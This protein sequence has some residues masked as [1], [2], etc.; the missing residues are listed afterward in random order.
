VKSDVAAASTASSL[1][2]DVVRTLLELLEE[3][4]AICDLNLVVVAHN[5]AFSHFCG[6]TSAEG[7]SVRELLDMDAFAMP[8]DGTVSVLK[9]RSSSRDNRATAVSVSRRG[10]A[11]VVTTRDLDSPHDSLAAA[12][13][14]LDA[15]AELEAQLLEIG[16]SV[17]GAS[18]EEELVAAV[19]RGVK[20]L[21]PG[22]MYC[23]RIIDPQTG[24]LTSLFAQGQLRLI[25]R[26]VL[27]LKQ[28]MV[29]KTH[30]DVATLPHDHIVFT[31]GEIPALFQDSV[32]AISAPLVASGRL[33][34]AINVE[35]AAEVTFDGPNNVRVLSQL[36]NQVAVA[37]RNAKLIDELTFVRK[38]LEEL[39]E[40]ANALI[41]VVDSDRR[42]AVFNDALAH[43]TG[44]SKQSVLGSSV[45][46]LLPESERFK[47]MKTIDASLS[48]ES[49]GALETVLV[50]SAGNVRVAF[51]LSPVR[52]HAGHIEGVMAIGHDLTRMRA[53]EQR[54]IQA[55]KLASLGKLAA[56][57][58]HEINNPMTAVLTYTDALLS[59]A[60]VT[61]GIE[62]STIE[63]YR[64]ILE[65]S[66]RV[67]RFT[68]DLVSYA[69]TAPDRAEDVD[70]HAV[71]RRALEYCELV[72]QS[73]RVK[74]SSSLADVPTFLGVR[75]NLIQV[76]VN[77][78]TNACQASHE[79]G[80]VA[81]EI[82]RSDGWALVSVA[83]TGC[84]IS[85]DVRNRI[86]EPFFTTKPD[87][88]G[89]G[90]GLSIV[91][92]IVERHGGSISLISTPGHG[93]IA[94]VR[95]PLSKRSS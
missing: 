76:F 57:V 11:V 25:G 1:S 30:L 33:L 79:G 10:N 45:V 70:L 74:L 67:L 53:L 7:R 59:R 49:F 61:P 12:G 46:D 84:G 36:A 93:T 14:A 21:F 73:R 82:V 52:A 88:Q 51:A 31:S 56:S 75:E 60:S 42:I 17:A 22:T 35:V 26:D 58:V 5:S 8:A 55:E 2:E 50:G 89:T 92:G 32:R 94:T 38:Y 20:R 54:M 95:L 68:R 27:Y 9:A 3:P 29:E 43:L 65:N 81:V 23:I 34:G 15:Q 47:F 63:K 41:L 16:R 78:I 69:R 28:S 24:G 19:A 85:E 64:R 83:D 18:G 66:E 40:H 90:L 71:I 13:R 72:A 44:R 87:G 86:F 6:T 91:Q 80:M 62:A 37:I 48:G 39:L 77:L 4:A